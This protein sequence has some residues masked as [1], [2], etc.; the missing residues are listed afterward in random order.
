[1]KPPV[2]RP[3]VG[4]V[5]DLRSLDGMPYHVQGAKYADAIA[6]CAGCIPVGLAP[7]QGAQA[8]RSLIA[9]LDG[10]VFTGSASNIAPA[11][12]GA[13]ADM[14]PYD[15]SRDRFA[16]PLVRLAIES[17]LPSLFICRGYQELNVAL[18]GTLVPDVAALGGK[19]AHH[20]PAHWPYDERYKPLHEVAL[21]PGSPL[22]EVFGAPVFRVNSLHYQGLGKLA[23]RLSVEGRAP[24]GLP[25]VVSVKDH[26]FA[27]GVQWHPE[28]R[29]DLNPTSRMLLEAFGRAVRGH[30]AA[31]AM[32]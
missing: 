4:L 30:A 24:D 21:T 23:D 6:E 8:L 3:L 18:G 15:P 10:L 12:Y 13:E 9:R 29:P 7:L 19:V 28:Y 27:I 5:S 32:E 20:P 11:E 1:M 2:L 14:P 26:P 31:K 25:E 16:L 17:G 22:L